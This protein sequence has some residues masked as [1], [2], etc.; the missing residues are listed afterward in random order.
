MLTLLCDTLRGGP[1]LGYDTYSHI[2]GQLF[3][4]QSGFDGDRP[5][6]RCKGHLPL[7]L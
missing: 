4:V 7:L 6:F 1:P 5:K 3:R 2:E